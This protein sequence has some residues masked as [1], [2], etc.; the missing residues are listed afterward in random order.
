[1]TKEN[2][3][4]L[5]HDYFQDIEFSYDTLKEIDGKAMNELTVEQYDYLQNCES[6]QCETDTANN[7]NTERYGFFKEAG[8][9]V[10]K[11]LECLGICTRFLSYDSIY[12]ELVGP[13]DDM[14]SARLKCNLLRINHYVE[15]VREILLSLGFVITSCVL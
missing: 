8:S 14:D 12:I 13:A 3:Y 11:W 9:Y 5:L 7:T 2:M 6:W 1:M 15:E 4:Q 10:C